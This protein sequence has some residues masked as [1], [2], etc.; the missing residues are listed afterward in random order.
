MSSPMQSEIENIYK[1]GLKFLSPLKPEETYTTIVQEAIKLVGAEYGDIYVEQHG[2]LVRVY[3]SSPVTYPSKHRRIDNTYRAFKE[4]KFIITDISEV[5]KGEHS[6]LQKLGLQSI[7]YIPLSYR[8]QSIGVLTVNAERKIGDSTV[9]LK[10]LKLFAFVASLAIKKTQLY[11]DTKK[12]LETRDLFISMAAHELRTPLTTI[13][14][15]IQLLHTK[16]SGADT[17]ESRWVEELVSESTRLTTLVNELL[18]VNRIKAG[19]LQYVWKECSLREVIARAVSDF[20]FN[21]PEY[22]LQLQ[23]S[24]GAAEDIVIGDFDKL[25]QVL[26]NL[27]DNAAKF[28]PEGSEINLTLKHKSSNMII[29]VEDKGHGI[30]RKDLPRIFDGFHQGRDPSKEGMGLGL[31]LAKNII[32]EHRGTIHVHS[33]VGK[34]TLIEVLLP[35]VKL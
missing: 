19:L 26:T 16:L 1:A 32:T 33:K 21:N 20:K 18:A 4:R 3:S 6:N 2:E 12:A 23:D 22:K 29:G 28:S 5:G 15:Y 17:P 7:L 27:L 34:G 9:E 24:L 13:N 10:V 11:E 30:A 14:G 31:F 25:L 35:R 8:N